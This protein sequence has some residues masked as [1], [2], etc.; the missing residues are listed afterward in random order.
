MAVLQLLM[1][2]GMA[3]LQSLNVAKIPSTFNQLAQMVLQMVVKLML[4]YNSSRVDF[5]TDR[6]PD[7]SIKNWER[8]RRA[9][10]GYQCIEIFSGD[11]KT[12]KQWK[13]F[14]NCGSNK[15]ALVEFLF[16]SWF[17]GVVHI[18]VPEVD[19][20]LA[21][22]QF[23]HQLRYTNQAVPTVRQISEL[24]CSHEEADTRLL[25]HANHAAR[26]GWSDVIIKSPDTDVAIISLAMQESCQA[27]IF[28]T[29]GKGDQEHIF[30]IHCIVREVGAVCR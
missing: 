2:D 27:N 8:S 18:A 15:E 21:H 13:K 17:Q 6:Y 23:C 22:G 19:V 26:S 10:A 28:F 24:T 5:V 29:T 1:V 3:V 4:L 7:F 30:D 11:Q 9:A 25:L 12:P 20:F 14:L 16:K